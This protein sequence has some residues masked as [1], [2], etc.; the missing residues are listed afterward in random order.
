MIINVLFGLLIIIGAFAITKPLVDLIVPQSEI[1]RI[2]EIGEWAK[3]QLKQRGQ[4]TKGG[5][6]MTLEEAIINAEEVADRCAA[7]DGDF[8]CEQEHR[9][10]ADW[11]KLLNGI[12]DSGNCNDCSMLNSQCRYAPKWGEQVRYNCPFYSKER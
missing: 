4:D 7:T 9:Q 6:R 2:D 12:L 3:E 1:D 5:I 8:K 10:L 11:L